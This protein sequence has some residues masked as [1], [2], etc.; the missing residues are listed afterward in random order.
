MSYIKLHNATD[1]IDPYSKFGAGFLTGMEDVRIYFK[2][3]CCWRRVYAAAA[4]LFGSR[5][6]M[7]DA[8]DGTAEW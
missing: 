5:M 8:G 3:N 2:K 7:L 6:K 1:F 4:E